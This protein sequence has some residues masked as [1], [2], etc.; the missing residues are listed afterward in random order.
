[1]RGK[2]SE[3]IVQCNID[4]MDSC[5]RH[6]S[7]VRSLAGRGSGSICT[8][9]RYFLCKFWKKLSVDLPYDT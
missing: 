2:S 4:F 5:S 6:L 9:F 8:L 7:R 1:M 3:E